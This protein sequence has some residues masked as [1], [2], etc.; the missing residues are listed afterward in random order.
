MPATDNP[1]GSETERVESDLQGAVGRYLPAQAGMPAREDLCMNSVT[2]NTFSAV[3]LVLPKSQVVEE[4][5]GKD[6]RRH[7]HQFVLSSIGRPI[8]ETESGHS[9]F[10]LATFTSEAMETS[11]QGRKEKSCLEDLKRPRRLRAWRGSVRSA[12][13]RRFPSSSKPV[14]W[15]LPLGCRSFR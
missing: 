14:G 10:P 9:W 5:N 6:A 11:Q 12:C 1:R 4:G 13:D 8:V 7:G 2:T 15:R 3:C